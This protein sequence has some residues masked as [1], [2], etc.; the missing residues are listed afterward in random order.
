L[1]LKEGK[2]FG[3]VRAGGTVGWMMALALRLHPGAHSPPEDVRAIFIVSGVI[4]LVLAAFSL[5]LP[6]TPPKKGGDD[7]LAWRRASAC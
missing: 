5:T 3:T 7:A 6:H 2:D 4:S 1:P